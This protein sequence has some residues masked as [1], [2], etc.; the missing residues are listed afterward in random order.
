MERSGVESRWRIS[1]LGSYFSS[2][3]ISVADCPTI[4]D[5]STNERF[6]L[7]IVP[8]SSAVAGYKANGNKNG[9]PVADPT[10]DATLNNIYDN[11]I[12]AAGVVQIPVCSGEE[13]TKNWDNYS[14]GSGKKTANYPCN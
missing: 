14:S 1:L 6:L 7:T 10:N 3:V 2:L 12:Q 9:W 8:T 11:G 5:G 13:A 4:T